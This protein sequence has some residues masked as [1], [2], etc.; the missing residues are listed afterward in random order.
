MRANEIKGIIHDLINLESWRNPISWIKNRFE[1]DLISGKINYLGEDDV[2]AFYKEKRQWFVD[3]VKKLKGDLKEFQYARIVLYGA[4]EK[5]EISYKGK[6][7]EKDIVYGD[8]VEKS[9]KEEIKN[10]K[11]VKLK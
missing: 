6:K 3:R 1:I 7:F 4:K 10:M 11:A 9:V 2:S 8:N 5:V